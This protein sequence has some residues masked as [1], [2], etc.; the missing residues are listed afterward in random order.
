M[1]ILVIGG[2]GTIGRNVAGR[3]SVSH[4]VIIAGRHSAEI[5]IDL[6]KEDSIREMFKKNGKF[7]AIVACVGGGKWEKFEGYFPAIRLYR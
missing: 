1:R 3:L 6:E 2:N 4:E 5:I 7:G